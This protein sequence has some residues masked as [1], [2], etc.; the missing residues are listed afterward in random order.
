[1]GHI[2]DRSWRQTYE[3][4]VLKWRQ[5]R[6]NGNIGY[7]ADI[8]EGTKMKLMVRSAAT[9]KELAGVEWI[10]IDVSG[11]FRLKTTDRV[12][13]YKT[14]FISENGDRYPILDKVTVNV[15]R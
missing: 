6:E 10:D 2:Y 4:S 9:E 5:R 14:V 1:M 12:M 11:K 15:V 13:Q 3:S 8:P 7:I